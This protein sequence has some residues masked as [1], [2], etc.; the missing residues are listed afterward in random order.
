MITLASSLADNVRENYGRIAAYIAQQAGEP[1]HLLSGAEAEEQFR[2][3]ADGR[4]H[5][6]FIC[7][8]PYTQKFDRPN[9]PVELLA[10]PVV[11]ARRYRCRPV[12]FTDVIV[13]RDSPY[14][15][16]ADLRGTAWAYNGCDSNS[17][18]NTRSAPRP[19]AGSR[20]DARSLRAHRRLRRA[21]AFASDL[22]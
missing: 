12:Y 1:A 19:P 22:S 9:P 17:G 15:T 6:A 8:L 7:G 14:Q 5:V 4:V 3:L 20:R 18:Y 13:R 2:M 21:P 10:A 11:Q 16:F